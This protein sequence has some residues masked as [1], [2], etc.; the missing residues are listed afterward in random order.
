MRNNLAHL[1]LMEFLSI[2]NCASLIPFKGLLI[3]ILYLNSKRTLCKET[4]ETDQ[5]GASD[6]GLYCLP[7]P[8]KE[9]ARFILVK[10][11]SVVLDCID[12]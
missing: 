3:G 4:L 9:D 8:H 5:M 12:F 10:L 11:Y 2:T 6:L 7:M 1:C